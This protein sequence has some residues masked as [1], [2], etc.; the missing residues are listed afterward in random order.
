M[1]ALAGCSGTG[2]KPSQ[3]PSIVGTL[4]LYDYAPLPDGCGGTGGYDDIRQGAGVTLRDDTG[5]I[6]ATSAL[7]SGV[8]RTEDLTKPYCAF[9]FVISNI[10][11][12]PF[13]SVEV[14]HRGQVTASLAEMRTSGW[15]FALELGRP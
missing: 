11:E 13:Y 14:S 12:V 10:P 15:R 1:I 9:S 8:L 2:A 3:A 4:A 6:I 5:R 7:S